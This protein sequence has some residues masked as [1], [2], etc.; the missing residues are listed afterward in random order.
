MRRGV[1]LGLILVLLLAALGSAWNHRFEPIPGSKPVTLD[2]IKPHVPDQKGLHW[3]DAD[4]KPVLQLSKAAEDPHVILEIPLKAPSGCAAIHLRYTLQANELKPGAHLWDDGRFNVTWLTHDHRQMQQLA[5]VRHQMLA[6]C[7]SL[8]SV[9]PH[10]GLDPQ[11]WIGHRGVSG[12]YEISDLEIVFVRQ[13]SWWGMVSGILL[14]AAGGWIFMGLSCI[15][16]VSVLRTIAASCVSL[17]LILMF[18]IPGPWISHMPLVSDTFELGPLKDPISVPA[19]HPP[20]SS[21][22]P[23]HHEIRKPSHPEPT[24]NNSGA[25][26]VPSSVIAPSL[27]QAP[28]ASEAVAPQAKTSAP[29]ATVIQGNWILDA[30]RLLRRV[31]IIPH[32]L[33]FGA[34]VMV[35]AGLIGLRPAVHVSL[36]LALATELAQLA[37]GYGS[38]ATDLLDLLYDGIGIAAGVWFVLL[39]SPLW[40]RSIDTPRARLSL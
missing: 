12:I 20:S 28:L 2:R 3:R 38:D 26:S 31:K 7:P 36:C 33:L 21:D 30:K 15:T 1:V 35:F 11:L 24:S 22:L 14:A 34:V 8:V 40:R 27:P 4:G 17:M 29:S 9:A 19:D 32:A 39:L 23:T 18:V 16:R 13:A 37:F 6:F 10:R 25:A 5:S